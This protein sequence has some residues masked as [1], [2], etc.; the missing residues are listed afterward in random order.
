M[1][2]KFTTINGREFWIQRDFYTGE[3]KAFAVIDGVPQKNIPY[4]SGR[5]TKRETVLYLEKI[6]PTQDVMR[7]A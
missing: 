4:C 7:S 2:D 3:W 1:T 5:T 6:V